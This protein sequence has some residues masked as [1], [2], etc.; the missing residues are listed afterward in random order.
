MI[1]STKKNEVIDSSW[2]F[3]IDIEE[4]EDTKK[5]K[6][7]IVKEIHHINHNHFMIVSRGLVMYCVCILSVTF[8][9]TFII[10]CRVFIQ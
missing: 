4:N 9:F 2:G 1:E 6:R 7:P 8:G 10:L 3:F 5:D